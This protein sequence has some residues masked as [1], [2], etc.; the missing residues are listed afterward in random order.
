MGTLAYFGLLGLGF[1][2][3]EIPLMQRFILFLGHPA[4]AMT[5]V[6]F[7]ILLFSGLGSAIS[8]RLSTCRA[9]ILLVGLVLLGLCWFLSSGGSL[10]GKS[11]KQLLWARCKHHV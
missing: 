5:T 8:H 7:A 6:L 2:L 1:M 3:V 9:L 4:Y 11:S 10:T